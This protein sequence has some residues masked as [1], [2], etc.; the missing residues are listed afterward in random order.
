MYLCIKFKLIWRTSD[1]KTKF[2]PPKNEHDT[3]LPLK[4][5]LHVWLLH[6]KTMLYC[7][8]AQL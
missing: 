1:F 5:T 6:A 4:I 7:Y 8:S 3:G 2:S